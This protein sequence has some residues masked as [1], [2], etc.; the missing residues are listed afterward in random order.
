MKRTCSL[1]STSEHKT[2]ACRCANV[3]FAV[4]V[5]DA[6]DGLGALSELFGADPESD[7]VALV[8]HRPGT[9]GKESSSS[10]G[11]SAARR[12]IDDIGSVGVAR[13]LVPA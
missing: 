2:L 6:C 10:L 8:L 3:C 5:G 9:R 7:S 1:T 13:L 11:T 4:M 12:R